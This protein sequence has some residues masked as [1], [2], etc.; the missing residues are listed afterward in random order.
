MALVGAIIGLPMFFEI[1]LVLLMPVI[2]LV[3]RRSELSADRGSAS[4]RWPACRRCTAWCRRTPARCVAIDALKRRPRHHPG[5]RRARRRADRRS[6]PARC[7]ARSPAAGS[8][9]P[10]PSMFD[11]PTTSAKRP[12]RRPSLRRHPAHR[13]AAGGADDGQ[14]ARRHRRRRPRTTPV[15][16]GPRRH[17]HPADRAAHRGDRRHV[18]P[19]PRRRAWHQGA[20]ATSLEKSLP[21]IAGILL[22]VA[23]G[24]GF[25][26]T[27]VDTGIGTLI[28]D[29]VAGQRRLACCC[30]PGWSRC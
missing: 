16:H 13:A 24:G 29:W 11:A 10:R 15:Q 14:G 19:R 4:R 26:Q 7:S 27:L 3:A 12:Q 21:P 2:F 9:S 5:A 30:S 28:A 25:K 23:A 22:I 1:G 17:R 20:I 18:H 8:T 6:S